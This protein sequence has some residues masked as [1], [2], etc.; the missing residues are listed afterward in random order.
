MWLRSNTAVRHTGLL[1]AIAAALT[2]STAYVASAG[3]KAIESIVFHALNDP[4]G[5]TPHPIGA[6]G[7]VP[8]GS[9]YGGNHPGT[10][11]RPA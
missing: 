9:L 10:D 6:P 1:L 8:R 4:K 11:K 5:A 3:P 2:V 7:A